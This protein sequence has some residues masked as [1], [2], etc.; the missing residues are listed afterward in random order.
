MI[1]DPDPANAGGADWQHAAA[2][3]KEIRLG[4]QVLIDEC[5]GLAKIQHNT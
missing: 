3:G 2:L 4:H 5:V 1:M